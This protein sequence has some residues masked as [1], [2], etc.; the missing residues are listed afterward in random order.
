[1]QPIVPS[2]FT[3]DGADNADAIVVDG[4][5]IST[6][7]SGWGVTDDVRVY[8]D[9]GVDAIA[10]NFAYQFKVTPVS[11]PVLGYA[12]L[13]G[14]STD[15][16]DPITSGNNR[17]GFS[18]GLN[19]VFGTETFSIS[20]GEVTFE[21]SPAIASGTE[22]FV[23]IWRDGET[24][25]LAVTTGGYDGT[26][27]FN[28][29]LSLPS[30]QSFRYLYITASHGVGSGPKFYS[31]IWGDAFQTVECAQSD[32]RVLFK[33]PIGQYLDECDII[34]EVID[35]NDRKIGNYWGVGTPVGVISASPGSLYYDKGA[36]DAEGALYVKILG[37]DSSGW[38]RLASLDSRIQWTAFQQYVV[39]AIPFAASIAL[40]VSAGTGERTLTL[41]GNV[42]P[43]TI[44]NLPQGGYL[45]IEVIQANGGNHTI[46]WSGISGTFPTL[47]VPD[48]TSTLVAIRGFFDGPRF[49]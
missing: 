19:G 30:S 49:I 40:D 48:G 39:Q 34:N 10:G 41:T 7:P 5:S 13:L 9:K 21:L 32:A 3:Q 25:Y 14:L 47:S 12:E 20:I 44:T 43:F 42:S 11:A 33:T 15:L 35:Q 4:D 37:E 29:S 17:D 28:Y 1:M 2:S 24:C 36:V 27:F 18:F 22:Y 16:S 38:S 26:P 31:Y 6:I 45:S 23:R 46:G 8:D